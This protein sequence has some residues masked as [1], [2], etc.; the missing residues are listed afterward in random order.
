MTE[1]PSP[2]AAGAGFPDSHL[3]RGGRRSALRRWAILGVP[4]AVVFGWFGY[5]WSVS[6]VLP[7]TEKYPDGK[8]KSLG[9]VKRD[10]WQVYRRHGHWVTYHPNGQK[11]SEGVYEMGEKKPTWLYWDEAGREIRG[12]GA[13]ADVTP[14]APA[15]ARMGRITPS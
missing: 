3:N 11:A 15:P 13:P 5:L 7:A 8:V 4:L 9:Y 6:G 1:A 12:T 10:G 14:P 2:P